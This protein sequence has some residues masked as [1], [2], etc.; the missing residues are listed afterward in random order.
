M[1]KDGSMQ[2]GACILEHAVRSVP[3][4]RWDYKGEGHEYGKIQ[5]GAIYFQQNIMSFD[6]F[7]LH[8]IVNKEM[9]ICLIIC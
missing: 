5:T 4:K 1:S 6:F 8:D 7:N 2:T 3:T 9:I